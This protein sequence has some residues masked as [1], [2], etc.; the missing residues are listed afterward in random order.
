MRR[1]ENKLAGFA[2]ASTPD[3]FMTRRRRPNRNI[4]ITTWFTHVYLLPAINFVHATLLPRL[5]Y[6]LE[7]EIISWTLQSR[8]NGR[9]FFFALFEFSGPGENPI[10]IAYP[11][12]FIVRIF[13]RFISVFSQERVEKKT[14]VLVVFDKSPTRRRF[15]RFST[16]SLTSSV[17]SKQEICC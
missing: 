1:Q 7:T 17:Y 16:R 9:Q 2:R 15:L 13:L 4:P 3:N 14:I 5:P 12:W 6:F 10:F 8:R 11:T